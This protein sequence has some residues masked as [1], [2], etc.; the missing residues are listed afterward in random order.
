MRGEERV[1]VA[2]R[3]GSQY[4][5]VEI[6]SISRAGSGFAGKILWPFI[7]N[8]QNAFFNQQLEHLAAYGFDN[9]R[10]SSIKE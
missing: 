10:C 7:G 9:K 1:T 5:D 4:V 6:L 8:M 2:L 3:D